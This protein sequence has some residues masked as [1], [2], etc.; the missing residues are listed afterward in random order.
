MSGCAGDRLA[1][2]R[3]RES[4]AKTRGINMVTRKAILAAFE[5][6]VNDKDV[7]TVTYYVDP[8]LLFNRIE[9]VRITRVRKGEQDFRVQMGKC[10]YAELKR[11]KTASHN[12]EPLPKTWIV[13]FK[14]K[15]AKK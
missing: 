12:G 13:M 9:R 10:N 11:V 5:L 7:K 8:K 1:R 14:R 2:S 3:D 15:A 6:I 4:P